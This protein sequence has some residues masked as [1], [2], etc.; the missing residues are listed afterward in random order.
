MVFRD[1]LHRVRDHRSFLLY[2]VV[3][4]VRSPVRVHFII[5]F[6]DPLRSRIVI[7]KAAVFGLVEL[8]VDDGVAFVLCG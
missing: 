4:Q 8:D 5:V 6:L 1:V 2:R 7:E 3:V